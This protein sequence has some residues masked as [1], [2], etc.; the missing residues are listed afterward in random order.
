[1]KNLLIVDDEPL[2]LTSIS[3]TLKIYDDDFNIVTAKNGEEAIAIIESAHVDLLITDLNMPV[4]SGY[5][6]I[7]HMS[8][9]HSVTPVIILTASDCE[10]ACKMLPQF[11]PGNCINKPFKFEMLLDLIYSMLDNGSKIKL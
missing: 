1:M 9:Q 3:E 2:N 6:L 5:E 7:A 10:A 8:K 4:K 11:N